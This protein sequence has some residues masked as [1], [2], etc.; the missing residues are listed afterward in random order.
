MHAGCVLQQW[1]CKEKHA[2]H[3]NRDRER[4]GAPASAKRGTACAA[5]R[6]AERRRRSPIRSGSRRGSCERPVRSRSRERLPPPVGAPARLAAEASEFRR[7]GHRPAVTNPSVRDAGRSRTAVGRAGRRLETLLL[8]LLEQGRAVQPEQLRRAVLVPVRLLER[9]QDQVGL[10]A[11]TTSLNGMPLGRQRAER[12]RGAGARIAPKGGGQVRRGRSRPRR[13]GSRGARSGS[14]ARARCRASR[15]RSRRS[16]GVARDARDRA[17]LLGVHG[18]RGSAGPGAA[19]PRA[20]RAAAAPR[21][22]SR[23]GGSRGPRGSAAR[24]SRPRGPGSSPRSRA[25]RP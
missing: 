15:R 22:G 21:S 5:A 20:A 4:A 19:R 16:S 17:A 3:A 8:D 10:E 18:A 1:A 24:G 6:R 12:R 2:R 9:L 7:S 13:A 23:S 25:R 14:R 11:S